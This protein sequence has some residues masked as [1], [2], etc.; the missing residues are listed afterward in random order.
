MGNIEIMKVTV[1]YVIMSKGSVK[2]RWKKKK[3]EKIV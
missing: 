3:E 2:G 1:I